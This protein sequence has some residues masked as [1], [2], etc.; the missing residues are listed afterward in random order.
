MKKNIQRC[1]HL[2]LYGVI[3][4]CSACS[5]SD[6]GLNTG[7]ADGVEVNNQENELVASGNST[8]QQI[9]DAITDLVA[10]TGVAEDSVVVTSAR[11]VTWSSGALGCPKQ[12]KSYTDALVPGLQVLLQAGGTTYH[13][14]GRNGMP[15]VYC[16]AERRQAP[17]LG[18]GA[19]VM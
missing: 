13:Y 16:P 1:I 6:T 14:H 12:G 9:D 18:M 2:G 15:L 11:A 19:E 5:Q 8:D 3:L 7:N 4:A 17:A 10:R